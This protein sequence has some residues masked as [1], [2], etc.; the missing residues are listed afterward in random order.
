MR[1]ATTRVGRLTTK[2]LPPSQAVIVSIH[3]VSPHT[4]VECEAIFAQ[5]A[6]LG[7]KTCT[8]LVVPDHHHRGPIREDAEFCEWL[9][10]LENAGHEI[11]IHGY[12]HQRERR[13]EETLYDRVVTRIYTQDE[14]EFYDLDYDRALALVRQAQ[15]EFREIGVHPEGFIAPA[16]LLSA[17][18]EEALKEA[19]LQYTTR[20]RHFRDLHTGRTY[21]AQSMVWS[22]RSWWRRLLSVAWN[23]ALFRRLAENPLM[24]IAIHPSD[25]HHSRVWRE[26]GVSVS[27]ALESRLPFTYERWLARQ[28]TYVPSP[29]P[30]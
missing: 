14:G 7:L 29:A 30:Q 16:W 11:V 3:D 15:E 1:I 22:S 17:P 21:E 5:L 18:A 8:W 27:R 4:R 20:L 24:R 2:L 23:R 9:C 19:G 12:H 6:A 25:L 26:I 28:R 13:T 10:A